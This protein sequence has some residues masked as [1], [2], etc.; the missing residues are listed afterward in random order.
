MELWWL[1]SVENS[2]IREPITQIIPEIA[3]NWDLCGQPQQRGQG[4]NEQRSDLWSLQAV[5]RRMSR[6]EARAGHTNTCLAQ[7]PA[8][9]NDQLQMPGGANKIRTN[10]FLICSHTHQLFMCTVTFWAI[11]G[12]SVAHDSLEFSPFDFFLSSFSDYACTFHP[13]HSTA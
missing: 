10:I 12:I 2:A 5:S 9:I 6:G 13:L 3:V 7:C 11:S 8:P 4:V 1:W